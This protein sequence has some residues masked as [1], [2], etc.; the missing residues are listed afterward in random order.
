VQLACR[1]D[2]DLIVFID[3]PA[4]QAESMVGTIVRAK[5]TSATNLALRAHL[6]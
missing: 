5:V 3:V 1:T 2:T 4:Q 6:I